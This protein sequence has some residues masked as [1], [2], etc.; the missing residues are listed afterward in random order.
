MFNFSGIDDKGIIGKLPRLPLRLLS[1]G[2]TVPIM[3]G[4]LRG[5][6]WIVGSSEHG[7][8]LGSYEF[9][10]CRRLTQ[11]VKV[12]AVFFD[13][14]ANVG[15]YS[16]LAAELVGP[17]GSVFAFEPLPRNVQLLA[18]HLQLN[19]V[20]N[21]TV[22]E[23]AVSDHSGVVRFQEGLSNGMGYICDKGA[24][25]VRA[26]SLDALVERGDYPLPDYIKMDIE[27]GEV[28]ALR[29][30]TCILTSGC[31]AIF[32]STHGR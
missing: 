1:R 5:R 9:A 29:G 23:A 12:G 10:K 4:R 19:R 13:I 16:L 24:L 15:F 28:A 32:L 8:W 6:R 25:P 26:V 21:C 14:G 20:R 2:L 3:Q 30:A 31:P 7:C 22:V 18:R 17:A 27:G 11:M